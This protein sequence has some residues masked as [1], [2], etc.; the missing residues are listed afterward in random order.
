LA[1]WRVSRSSD[2]SLIAGSETSLPSTVVDVHPQRIDLERLGGAEAL[3]Q[4][5]QPPLVHQEADRAEV[6]AEH[7]LDDVAFQHL[8]QHLQH[9]AIAAKCDD[10]IRFR[11]GH[12]LI[13]GAQP[14][15]RRPSG[16][17]GRH[18]Q[19]AAMFH[20]CPSRP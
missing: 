6:H 14:L 4:P 9:E 12:E 10:Q 2:T 17:C 7:R 18:H 15:L 13:A 8:V 1:V 3:V 11:R 16:G 5:L 19:R 20:A